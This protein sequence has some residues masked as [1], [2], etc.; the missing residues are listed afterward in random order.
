MSPL[1]HSDDENAKSNEVRSPINLDAY[2]LEDIK[3]GELFLI[4]IF[5]I[6]LDLRIINKS[7]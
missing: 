3:E 2:L 1:V 5:Y 7:N 6:L 4:L